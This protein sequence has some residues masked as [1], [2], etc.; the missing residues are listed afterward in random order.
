LER[1][2]V[3][4]FEG[5]APLLARYRTMMCPL[6]CAL[7]LG[8]DGGRAAN[9]RRPTALVLL[10]ILELSGVAKTYSVKESVMATEPKRQEPDIPAQKPDIQPE[11]TPQE[12]PQDKDVPEKQTPP[13]QL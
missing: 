4:D 7:F 2:R 1:A 9:M 10:S 13:M 6:F 3:T 5:G 12:I 11:P 8:G